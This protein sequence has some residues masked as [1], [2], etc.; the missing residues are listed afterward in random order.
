MKSFYSLKVGKV[1]PTNIE[2]PI[3]KVI[4]KALLVKGGLGGSLAAWV[5]DSTVARDV[6]DSLTDN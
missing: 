3:F 2:T 1:N 6:V 5:E 4:I